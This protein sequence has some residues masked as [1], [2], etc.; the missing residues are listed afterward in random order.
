MNTI[1]SINPCTGNLMKEYPE[2]NNEQIESIISKA[3]EA[4]LKWKELSFDS[5]AGYMRKA[6]QIMLDRKQE[7][8][9][10]CAREM[11][12]PM[13]FGDGET[14]V[15]AMILNYYADNAEKFLADRPLA[16]PLNKAFI[17]YEPLG[18]IL[19]VQPWNAPFYQMVRSAGPHIM[20]GNTMIMKQASNVPQCAQLMEDIFNEAGLPQGYTLIFF[21]KVPRFHLF[22]M[23]TEYKVPPSREA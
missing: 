13:V 21:L 17:A 3:H 23:I 18:V 10:V 15:C 16:T 1:K 8:S 9:E 22:S 19:S 14:E 11:G 6:A 4:F 5:R 7:I 12:K 2:M 20:A